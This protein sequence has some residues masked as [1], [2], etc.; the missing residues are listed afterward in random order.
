MGSR[1]GRGGKLHSPRSRRLIDALLTLVVQA[2]AV[3]TERVTARTLRDVV[4][5]DVVSFRAFVVV[6]MHFRGVVR[7]RMPRAFVSHNSY[8]RKASTLF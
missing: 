8:L 2:G 3:G 4:R 1:R 6:V 5:L 7:L